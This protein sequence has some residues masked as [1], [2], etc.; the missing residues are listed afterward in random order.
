MVLV[1]S[2]SDSENLENWENPP[3]FIKLLKNEI[4]R[5]FI[6]G[7]FPTPEMENGNPN[8]RNFID[9]FLSL[10]DDGEEKY[11]EDVFPLPI[12]VIE[13]YLESI[14]RK[15]GVSSRVEAAVYAVRNNLLTPPPEW[16]CCLNDTASSLVLAVQ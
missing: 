7:L 5:K 10:L 13:K 12:P 15:L 11:G 1:R 4:E 8:K 6:A 16:V 2:E 14:L 9:Y 3:N